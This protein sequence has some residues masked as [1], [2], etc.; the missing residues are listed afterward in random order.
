MNADEQFVRENWEPDA[1]IPID[2]ETTLCLD[3]PYWTRE[4]RV[5]DQLDNDHLSAAAAFTRNRLAEIADVEAEIALLE[6]VEVSETTLGQA[7]ND[8]RTLH[9]VQ[10]R[11]QAALAE[12]QSG[13]IVKEAKQ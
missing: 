1:K 11:E 9:R 2:A 7:L 6:K 5:D 8:A 10:I 4:N 3:D 12:L 13:M